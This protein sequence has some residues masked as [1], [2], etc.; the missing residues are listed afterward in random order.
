MPRGGLMLRDRHS[1]AGSSGLHRQQ[2]ERPSSGRNHELN[3][4][5]AKDADGLCQP[6]DNLKDRASLRVAHGGL[7]V[8]NDVRATCA[9]CQTS[10]S[11]EGTK[12]GP[13]YSRWHE[14]KE[15]SLL[16]NAWREKAEEVVKQTTGCG[17]KGTPSINCKRACYPPQWDHFRDQRR[18]PIDWSKITVPQSLIGRVGADAAMERLKVPPT[19]TT[20]AQSSCT[21]ETPRTAVAGPSARRDTRSSTKKRVSAY[22]SIKA[23][24]QIR[25]RRDHESW[26]S[27]VASGLHTPTQDPRSLVGDCLEGNIRPKRNTERQPG[28]SPP[29]GGC[30]D[31]NHE[32][33]DHLNIIEPH[34]SEADERAAAERREFLSYAHLEGLVDSA[35]RLLEDAALRELRART[36]RYLFG[37]DHDEF[38]ENDSDRGAGETIEAF[39]R[40]CLAES[41]R[42]T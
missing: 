37:H 30:E 10:I 23:R 8:G 34:E 13:V 4:S 42:I 1:S 18:T 38:E 3:A 25:S 5:S 9:D 17:A 19:I 14:I 20:C 6:D 40:R 11:K 15:S 27:R 26:L 33:L 28:M 12:A 16:A 2:T 7:E 21:R 24:E 31:S 41:K 29:P 39:A 36:M 35:Q 22:L 32:K